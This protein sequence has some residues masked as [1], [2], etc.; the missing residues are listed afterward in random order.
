MES[1][2][3]G[4]GRRER[5][6]RSRDHAG[7]EPAPPAGCRRVAAGSPH[8]TRRG[9]ELRPHWPPPPLPF[10]RGRGAE[11]ALRGPL[12]RQS[13]PL[14]RPL[15]SA[16]T[17]CSTPS[18]PLPE[19]GKVGRGVLR[20]TT[21]PTPGSWGAQIPPPSLPPVWGSPRYTAPGVRCPLFPCEGSTARALRAPCLAG[22]NEDNRTQPVLSATRACPAP[23]TSEVPCITPTPG[24]RESCSPF[25]LSENHAIYMLRPPIGHPPGPG[26]IPATPHNDTPSPREAQFQPP[27]ICTRRCEARPLFPS[28]ALQHFPTAKPPCLSSWLS[29]SIATTTLHSCALLLSVFSL[30]TSP[31]LAPVCC[32]PA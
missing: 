12:P 25:S 22:T 1:P 8:R 2:V 18:R 10:R 32:V 24:N 20:C 21:P 15:I 9:A 23:V 29:A 6:G 26:S 11:P 3:R 27:G 30:R 14:P 31:F 5:R 16:P 13:R 4:G 17:P 19:S 7:W 28:S